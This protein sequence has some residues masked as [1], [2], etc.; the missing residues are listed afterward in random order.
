M[1]DTTS[2]TEPSEL[3]KASPYLMRLWTGGWL[4]KADVERRARG[5]QR[6]K[7]A[8]SSIPWYARQAEKD[9]DYWNVFFLSHVNKWEPPLEASSTTT[10]TPPPF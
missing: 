6:T 4:E 9:P 1:P 7:E 5:A 3:V 10:E 8:F 2:Q